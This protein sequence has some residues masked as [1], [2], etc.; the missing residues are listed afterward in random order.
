M[1]VPDRQASDEPGTACARDNLSDAHEGLA[2]EP[3]AQFIEF[4]VWHDDQLVPATAEELQWIRERERERE[5]RWRLRQWQEE[6]RRQARAWPVRW[7]HTGLERTLI[8]LRAH[9]KRRAPADATRDR[10]PSRGI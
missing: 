7:V 10:P 8:A 4:W 1:R 3:G 9:R 6:Q 2:Q 5:A